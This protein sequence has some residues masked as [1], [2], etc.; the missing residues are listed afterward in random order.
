MEVYRIIS[1]C[2]LSHTKS[3][4]EYIV[5]WCILCVRFCSMYVLEKKTKHSPWRSERSE[6]REPLG[7]CWVSTVAQLDSFGTT[8]HWKTPGGRL[9]KEILICESWDPLGSHNI[10]V[11]GVIGVIGMASTFLES[12]IQLLRYRWFRRSIAQRGMNRWTSAFR[13]LQKHD[14]GE[15]SPSAILDRVPE[16]LDF[17][18]SSAVRPVRQEMIGECRGVGRYSPPSHQICVGLFW[19]LVSTCFFGMSNFDQFLL[20]FVGS[21]SGQAPSRGKE[22]A[23]QR[24]NSLCYRVAGGLARWLLG[25]ETISSQIRSSAPSSM[26][27]QSCHR[28]SGREF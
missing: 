16:P 25:H 27:C 15:C 5:F 1:K 12:S 23:D 18:H 6:C 17:G 4:K 13:I 7:H 3:I 14:P 10:W 2:P 28:V 11:I 26:T 19:K 20:K 24:A 9:G 8:L 21:C 22:V